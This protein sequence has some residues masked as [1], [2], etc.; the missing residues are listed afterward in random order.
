MKIGDWIAYLVVVLLMACCVWAGYH[1]GKRAA[2][3]WHDKHRP[4]YGEFD[5]HPI[6]CLHDSTCSVLLEVVQRIPDQTEKD[7]AICG[8]LLVMPSLG[9][10]KCIL[11]PS[12]KIKLRPSRLK[13][14]V[15]VTD[16]NWQ[17][18]ANFK[19]QRDPRFDG[20]ADVVNYW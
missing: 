6:D 9:I 10:N 20:P 8:L 19:P 3:R 16:S 11:P 5:Y 15:D 1:D 12:Y 2:D 14:R 4:V 17:P 7:N 13:L 18:P